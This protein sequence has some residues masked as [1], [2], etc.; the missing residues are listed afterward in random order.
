M[1]DNATW[2]RPPLYLLRELGYAFPAL[3]KAQAEWSSKQPAHV[4]EVM[5]QSDAGNSLLH[6]MLVVQ[7]R[8]HP[9]GKHAS[10][11]VACSATFCRT[12][13]KAQTWQFSPE[14]CVLPEAG[15]SKNMFLISPVQCA[16][17]G[18]TTVWHI[19]S[20]TIP[21]TSKEKGKS[22]QKSSNWSSVQRWAILG[23]SQV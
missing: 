8:F 10:L 19:T 9:S 17:R 16:C 23:I 3:W 1:D 5:P 2:L 6:L 14:E 22:R 21:G 4:V 12:K 20:F 11:P 13:L 7:H 15:S 18:K